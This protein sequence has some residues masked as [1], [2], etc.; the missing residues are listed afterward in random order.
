MVEGCLL[1]NIFFLCNQRSKK[2]IEPIFQTHNTTL[3]SIEERA[4]DRKKRKKLNTST[5]NTKAPT[6]FEKNVGNIC[7]AENIEK[8]RNNSIFIFTF[9][10]VYVVIRK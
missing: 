6:F 1:L 5:T 2:G 10:E 8:T 3:S 9:D 4:L 7:Y